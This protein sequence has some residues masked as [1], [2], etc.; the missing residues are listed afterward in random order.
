MLKQKS[1][2]DLQHLEPLRLGFIVTFVK[3][4]ITKDLYIIIVIEL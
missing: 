1:S 4:A 3:A 2:P